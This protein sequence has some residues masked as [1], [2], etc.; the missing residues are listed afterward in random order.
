MVIRFFTTLTNAVNPFTLF[1]CNYLFIHVIQLL[2]KPSSVLSGETY[3]SDF[4]YCL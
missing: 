4:I 2:L 1:F 3:S